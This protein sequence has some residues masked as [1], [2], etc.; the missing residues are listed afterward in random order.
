MEAK[1]L[2]SPEFME[3]HRISCWA[4]ESASPSAY[5]EVFAQFSGEAERLQ[6]N[7]FRFAVKFPDFRTSPNPIT[8]TEKLVVFQS[9]AV[10]ASEFLC[11]FNLGSVSLT[12]NSLTF[13][14]MFSHFNTA[15]EKLFHDFESVP[16]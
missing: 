5:F 8:E 10:C 16:F 2:Q 12:E 3:A 13:S 1:L 15:N 9:F 4:L 14:L 6:V 7:L 11:I